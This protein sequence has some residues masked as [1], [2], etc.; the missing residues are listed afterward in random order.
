MKEL[1]ANPDFQLVFWTIVKIAVILNGLLGVVS[2]MIL[3]ERKV[4]GRM[5]GRPGPNRVGPVA[6]V[7]YRRASPGLSIP[8]TGVRSGVHSTP[9]RCQ[10]E[11]TLPGRQ[12]GFLRKLRHFSGIGHQ[13][14]AL[15]EQ[16]VPGSN[17]GA[18]MLSS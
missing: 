18:P 2:Y 17:P 5:Q 16:E 11:K 8:G 13:R 6:G 15:R 10:N 1:F 14:G 9:F 12:A 4:A 3:A 7:Y